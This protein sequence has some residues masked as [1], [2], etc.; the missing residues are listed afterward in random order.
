[1][2]RAI[3][4]FALLSLAACAM[5]AGAIER[6]KTPDAAADAF[7]AALGTE[8][9]DANRLAALLGANWQEYIPTKGIERKDVD[10]FIAYYREKHSIDTATKG[11]A[12]VVVGNDPWTLPIPIVQGKE[13]WS[14]DAK[15]G[16]EEIRLRRIGRNELSAIEA[17]EAYHDA[18]MD[19][20]EVDRN[21]D[22]ILEY[23]QKFISSDGQHDGLYWADEDGTEES[24]LGPLF[25]GQTKGD[26][27]HGY[28]FRI[29]TAQG[30]SAPG[31][32]YGYM[33]GKAMSRGF[34]LVAWPAQYGDS[35]VMSFMI[36]HEGQVFQKDLGRD[37]EKIAKAMK[38]FDP[39]SSWDEVKTDDTP[40]S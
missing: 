21:G 36:S 13:G 37:S 8:K 20:A 12:H 5:G 14:F 11:R 10:A 35:G 26:D 25:G 19:Y 40:D 27:W 3:R 16:G 9:A 33:L 6:F 29:L 23:A 7:V 34:A 30:P 2:N 4:I 38:I 28:H 18:Q 39:D 31:G 32:A 17:A 15:A 22:G 24:P 1:M